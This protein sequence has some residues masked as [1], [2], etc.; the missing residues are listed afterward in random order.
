M[1]QKKKEKEQTNIV[2]TLERMNHTGSIPELEAR[3]DLALFYIRNIYKRNLKR[4][5]ALKNE[6]SNM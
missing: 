3:Y 1:Q 5:L 6:F 4:L 2:Q